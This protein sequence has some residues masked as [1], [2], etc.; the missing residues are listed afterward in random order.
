MRPL[1]A[2]SLDAYAYRHGPG[3]AAYA[4]ALASEKRD[5]WAGVVAACREARA[6]DPAH[7]DAAWLEAAGLARQGAMADMLEPLGIAAAGDWAK[8]GERSLTLPLFADFRASPYGAAWLRVAEK[9]RDAYGAALARAVIA[10]GRPVASKHPRDPRQPSEVFAYDPVDKR[11]LRLTRSGGTIA[12]VLDAPGAPFLA[13]VAL[14]GAGASARVR[15]GAIDRA[16]GKVGRELDLGAQP[17]LALAWRPSKNGEPSLEVELPAGHHA[18]AVWRVDWRR[19]SKTRGKGPLPGHGVAVA[20]GAAS[21]DRLPIANVTADWDDD[22]VASAFRIE[23]S[24]K[25]IEPPKVVDGDTM[26]WSPDGVRLAYASLPEG[27]CTAR[28]HVRVEV[29]HAATGKLRSLGTADAPGQ[30]RWVDGG[31]VAYVVDD[32]IRVVDASTGAEI[33]RLAGGG[34]LALDGLVRGR[35]CDADADPAVFSA[36]PGDP[37]DDD[38]P[39]GDDEAAEPPRGD[40]GM[41]DAQPASPAPR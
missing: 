9:Y 39:P 28:Q 41:F 16:S 38:E 29:V 12:A 37:G 40:G 23:T 6:A 26:T 1:G 35:G 17:R 30:V 31:R 27:P 3:A 21:R 22:H 19:G 33:A 11:W 13:Y 14:R 7:V 18:S 10:I 2:P 5:D 36:D 34:G 4:R 25:T 15:I 24:G 32:A 20:G 8:W